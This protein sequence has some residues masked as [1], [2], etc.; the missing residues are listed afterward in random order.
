MAGV[1]VVLSLLVVLSTAGAL[2]PLI[3]ADSGVQTEPVPA[4]PDGFGF[5]ATGITWE[6]HGMVLDIGPDGSFDVRGATNPFVLKDSTTYRMWY[7]ARDWTRN[8]M[9]YATSPDG[10]VWTKEGLVLDVQTPPYYF[11]SVAGQSVMKDG[12]TYKMWFGGGFWSGPFGMSGQIYLATSPDALSWTIA[13]PVFAE[14][15]VGSWDEAWVGYPTV[16]RDPGGTYWLY[17]SGWDGTTTRI[18]GAT[19]SDGMA[20]TRIG[21][22]PVLDLGPANSWE[23]AELNMPV[24]EPGAPRTLWY[25][26]NGDKI[27]IG[28]ATSA[29]GVV[30]TKS[31][32]NPSLTEGP[33]GS[34]EDESVYGPGILIDGGTTWLYY[35][36][37]TGGLTRVGLARE[38]T[39]APPVVNG[40]AKCVPKTI[41]LR[42]HGR[43]I[44]CHPEPDAPYTSADIAAV[45]VKLDSWLSPVL[46]GPYGWVWVW[47][48]T[49]GTFLKFDRQALAEKLTVGDHIFLL[50]GTF[51][52]GTVFK[53]TSEIIR[54]IQ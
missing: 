18:G 23:D 30:W 17:Y 19:S 45:S 7:R 8:R 48:T 3:V 52:D 27:R 51:T 21:P 16:T 25:S 4:L 32:D 38:I 36:G 24:V 54:V 39:Q 46:D 1:S 14:G 6:R 44:T 41:N 13:G 42:S 11:D 9:M 26:A 5:G 31:A 37:V 29:D 28:Y 15:P 33:A 50:E 34:W 47:N 20:F 2:A 53:L 10:V 22:N 12:S 35:G 49:G 43:W 40:T